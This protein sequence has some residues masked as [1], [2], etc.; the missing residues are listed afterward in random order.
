M[1]AR[2]GAVG[3]AHLL[4]TNI[5]VKLLLSHV[6]KS[7]GRLLQRGALLVG[8]LGNL[9]VSTKQKKETRNEH[10]TGINESS[11]DSSSQATKRKSWSIVGISLGL[12]RAKKVRVPK[13]SRTEQTRMTAIRIQNDAPGCVPA[14]IVANVWVQGGDK[15]QRVLQVVSNG[16]PVGDHA[17]DALVS[18]GSR[19]L[20]QEDQ[21]VQEVV[22]NHWLEYVELQMTLRF[23]E[24]RNERVRGC[25]TRGAV[26]VLYR[27]QT[28]H[29]RNSEGKNKI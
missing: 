26:D 3:V 29:N 17:Q 22:D 9:A 11:R 19:A 23:N 18:K 16:G 8:L 10:G 21:G 2:L 27:S 1:D 13:L 25:E 12:V 15:H 14:L 20:G 7:N 4:W 5:A 28:H 24:A 6:A